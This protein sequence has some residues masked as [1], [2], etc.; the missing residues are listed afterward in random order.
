MGGVNSKTCLAGEVSNFASGDGNSIGFL[1]GGGGVFKGL[2]GLKLISCKGFPG[3]E[4][5]LTKGEYTG[6]LVQDLGS[7]ISEEGAFA[8][9]GQEEGVED[10]GIG[11]VSFFGFFLLEFSALSFFFFFFF[12]FSVLV[13]CF[14][15][16][17]FFSSPLLSDPNRV[18]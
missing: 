8:V 15:W 10:G 5:R 6:L 7:V 16:V 14:L 11:V 18:F 12:S 9:S 13:F 2:E 3:G 17:S 1:G 4:G